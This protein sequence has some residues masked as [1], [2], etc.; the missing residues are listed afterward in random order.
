[1]IR[2]MIVSICGTL[3][4]C[5]DLCSV[6]CHMQSDFILTDPLRGTVFS[7]FDDGLKHRENT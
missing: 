4:K 3:K 5:P 2:K 6:L 7:Y 1:M